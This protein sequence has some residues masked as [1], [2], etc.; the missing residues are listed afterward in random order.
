MN[1]EGQV[2]LLVSYVLLISIPCCKANDKNPVWRQ[3]GCHLVGFS[4]LIEVDDCRTVTVIVN[5]CRGYCL[6]YSYPSDYERYISGNGQQS[7][8]STGTCCS[9]HRTHDVDVVL[10][11]IDDQQRMVTLRSAAQ[12]SCSLC[13]L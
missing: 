8:T 7:V 6:S 10:S 12:C 9:V 3:P 4:K 5:A 11:C 1:V 13:E 2:V